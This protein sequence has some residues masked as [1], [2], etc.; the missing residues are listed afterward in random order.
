MPLIPW[1]LRAARR[2]PRWPRERG[3]SPAWTSI[4]TPWNGMWRAGSASCALTRREA[5]CSPHSGGGPSDGGPRW[6]WPSYDWDGGWPA[7]EARYRAPR[8]GPGARLLPTPLAQPRRIV[9]RH[10][11]ATGLATREPARGGRL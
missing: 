7:E 10:E 4:R 11:N 5:D 8:E 6:P 3:G 9:G 2:A 1:P